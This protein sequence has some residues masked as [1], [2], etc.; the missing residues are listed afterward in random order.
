MVFNAKRSVDN[1]YFFYVNDKSNENLENQFLVSYIKRY[2]ELVT[3]KIALGVSPARIFR[4]KK[5]GNWH[6]FSCLLLSSKQHILLRKVCRGLFTF[7]NEIIL[8][9]FFETL[10]L[11]HLLQTIVII[12]LSWRL[13][14]M[15]FKDKPSEQQQRREPRRR[16]VRSSAERIRRQ[17]PFDAGINDLCQLFVSF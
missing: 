6:P 11:T 9:G 13:L 10:C 4:Q 8:A 14:G 1:F 3:L 12:A 5:D 15:L 2:T 17:V 16:G 7:Q